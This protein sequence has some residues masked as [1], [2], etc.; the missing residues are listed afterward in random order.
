MSNFEK[1]WYEIGSGIAVLNNQDHEEHAMRISKLAWEAQERQSQSQ[2]LK[3]TSCGVPWV[4]HMGIIGT[5]AENI[6]LKKEVEELRVEINA[7]WILWFDK[8]KKET[9]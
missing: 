9:K 1:W 3:C 6:K 2:K 7:M 8:E 5:C 4:D